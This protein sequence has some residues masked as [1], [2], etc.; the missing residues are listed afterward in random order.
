MPRAWPYFLANL[1][2]EFPQQFIN[3]VVLFDA[4]YHNYRKLPRAQ[5]YILTESQSKFMQNLIC[6]LT[7]LDGKMANLKQNTNSIS[8]ICHQSLWDIF[9]A[10]NSSCSFV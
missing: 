3:T 7:W 5:P 2:G 1:N 6:I 10:N 4:K 8:L 9:A